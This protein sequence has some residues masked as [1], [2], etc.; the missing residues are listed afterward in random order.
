MRGRSGR[1]H[2]QA[3]GGEGGGQENV[4]GRVEGGGKW[5]K[6]A[7]LFELKDPGGSVHTSTSFSGSGDDGVHA[8]VNAAGADEGNVVAVV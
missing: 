4:R 3:A 6:R 1:D 8:T 7:C 2:S 5:C